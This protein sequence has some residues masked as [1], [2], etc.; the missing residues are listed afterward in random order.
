MPS[1]KSWPRQRLHNGAVAQCQ[2]AMQVLCEMVTAISPR[3]GTTEH[4]PG[5]PCIMT[6][7]LGIN[8]KDPLDVGRWM[9]WCK[10]CKKYFQWAS[11]AI[12]EDTL[13]WEGILE[14]LAIV[15]LLKSIKCTSS[16]LLS[17]QSSLSLV[18]DQR[19]SEY[20]LASDMSGPRDST[21]PAPSLPP[22]SIISSSLPSSSLPPASSLLH[23]TSI[24]PSPD[25]GAVMPS[26]AVLTILFWYKASSGIPLP[27]LDITLIHIHA[28]T[29]ISFG[30]TIESSIGLSR[31]W[32]A[33]S[34]HMISPQ[35][36]G[37][38]ALVPLL[39]DA[40]TTAIYGCT[41][42]KLE[43][44]ECPGMLDQLLLGHRH[45]LGELADP[46]PN[47][48]VAPKC[49]PSLSA[50]AKGKKHAHKEVIDLT[51]LDPE[52]DPN[53][54]AASTVKCRKVERDWF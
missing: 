30:V 54:P 2:A 40:W 9:K 47:E 45:V 5:H 33:D 50:L 20:T 22:S 32:G 44:E 7:C 41:A 28:G 26:G 49:R 51:I 42:E 16:N 48:P 1:S 15:H 25:S 19:S 11:P 10:D 31:M 38:N 3:P 36:S 18:L 46:R 35:A 6:L 34:N 14:Q 37:R 4:Q 13:Q 23:S 27:L 8:S 12:P 43:P 39:C 24:S 53:L 17:K 29:T 52:S 21:S